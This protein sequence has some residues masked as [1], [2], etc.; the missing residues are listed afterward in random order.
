MALQNQPGMYSEFSERLNANPYTQ[1]S[2][3]LMLRKKA[4]EDAMDEYYRRMNDNINQEGLRDIDVPG[5]EQRINTLKQYTIQNK[6]RL[7]KGDLQAQLERD[8]LFRNAQRYVSASKDRTQAAK[9]ALGTLQWYRENDLDPEDVYPNIQAND[10]PL[11]AGEES[12]RFDG[13]SFMNQPKTLDETV[14]FDKFKNTPRSETVEFGKVDPKTGMRVDT[15]LKAFTPET[16][17]GLAAQFAQDY[18][19]KYSFNQRV[20]E[21]IKDP[22]E[23]ESLANLFKQ[24]FGHNPETNEDYAAAYGIRRLQPIIKEQGKPVQDAVFLENLRQKNR[25]AL[26]GLK[27]GYRKALIEY[28]K[29]GS[30]EAGQNILNEFIN[31]QLSDPTAKDAEVTYQGS[32]YKGKQVK[33]PKFITDQYSINTGTKE[34][35]NWEDPS[36]IVSED[37]KYVIPIYTKK[38]D[39]RGG[40][41]KGVTPDSKPI[42]IEDYK[43]ML[44]KEWLSKSDAPTDII[45]GFEGEE[46]EDTEQA[47]PQT[48]QKNPTYKIKGK[49]YTEKQ[50]LDMGY[51]LD[52]IKPYK[53]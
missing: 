16:K 50:L 9:E 11:D 51:T 48:T 20:K 49:A 15:M 14:Y 26:E 21:V 5:F 22:V 23:R 13:K 17:Q 46:I 6:D 44:A 18:R 28:R 42:L 39:I 29:S 10:L 8:R 4:Q 52:D 53:N 2:A 25:R 31:R 36:W 7:R 34:Q 41:W 27:Q 45:E 43:A 40:G 24:E 12:M 38:G 19:K 3:Q 37:K 33:M 30:G 35:P 1:F 32:V 47:T